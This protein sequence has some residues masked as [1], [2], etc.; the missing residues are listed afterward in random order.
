MDPTTF[1]G[2]TQTNV[3]SDILLNN[4]NQEQ[5]SSLRLF[6]INLPAIRC[7][8]G[9]LYKVV[10]VV[11]LITFLI[12][13]GMYAIMLPK[14]DNINCYD[15]KIFNLLE[16]FNNFLHNHKGYRNALLIASS[17][18]IDLVTVS[19]TL[20]WLFFT[21]SWRM[22]STILMFYGFRAVIQLN[23]QLKFP[24]GF[25]WEYPGFPS[26]IVNYDKTNDFFYSGHVGMP[27][28]AALEWRKNGYT[29]P[30][31]FC[32]FTSCFEAFMLFIGRVHYTIDVIAG[33]AFAHYFYMINDWLFSTY[34]DKML[35]LQDKQDNKDKKLGEIS[36]IVCDE[37]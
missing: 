25:I 20:Y 27:L 18:C 29:K 36:P 30:V 34:I 3:A 31:I 13:N 32:V 33:V 28:I 1:S 16:S 15:D 10:F 35:G 23:F 17:V 24:E 2:N 26:L 12:I 8:R 9:L 21:K 19:V 37:A 6:N 11:I 4:Q 7:D 5:N 22:I 14:N